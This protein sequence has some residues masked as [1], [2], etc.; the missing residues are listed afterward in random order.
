MSSLRSTRA[1]KRYYWVCCAVSE[2]K[3][4]PRCFKTIDFSRGTWHCCYLPETFTTMRCSNCSDRRDVATREHSCYCYL[5]VKIWIISAIVRYDFFI[6][7]H[8]CWRLRTPL[9]QVQT[10][11]SE[12]LFRIMNT[13]TPQNIC[14]S[15]ITETVEEKILH[16]FYKAAAEQLRK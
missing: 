3:P 10:P 1:Q 2:M 9:C 16:V 13:H 7:Y 6:T 8:T 5:T 15:T 14:K 11:D 4:F 12:I